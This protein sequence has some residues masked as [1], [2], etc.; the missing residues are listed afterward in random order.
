MDMSSCGTSRRRS[1]NVYGGSG[2]SA[3]ETGAWLETFRVF[4]WGRGGAAGVLKGIEEG[5]G[6]LIGDGPDGRMIGA[7][8]SS[9]GSLSIDSCT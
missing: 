1:T 6:D 4:R 8:R 7:G 9:T 2:S 5:G 3:T